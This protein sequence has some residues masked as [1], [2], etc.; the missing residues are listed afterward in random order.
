MSLLS[1]QLILNYFPDC[2]E[3]PNIKGDCAIITNDFEKAKEIIEQ[4]ARDPNKPIK[5]VRVSKNDMSVIYE[6]GTR[7]IWL[8]PNA[9]V[10]GYCITK[11]IID[12][13]IKIDLELFINCIVYG[14]CRFCVRKNVEVI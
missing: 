6:D 5:Q 11:V 8:R 10:R 4:F 13:N 7:W 9:N 2:E 3:H 12:S 1:R 14:A